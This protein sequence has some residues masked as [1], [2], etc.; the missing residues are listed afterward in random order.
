MT[1]GRPGKETRGSSDSPNERL[2]QP[3]K[4]RAAGQRGTRPE[5]LTTQEGPLAKNKKGPG[6]N[7]DPSNIQWRDMRGSNPRPPT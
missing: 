2:T 5:R 1:Q 4:R 3:T 7:Q 6:V